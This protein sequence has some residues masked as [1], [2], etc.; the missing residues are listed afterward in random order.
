MEAYLPSLGW[1]GFD[2]TN[3]IMAAERHIRAAVGRDYADGKWDCDDLTTLTRVLNRGLRPVTAVQDRVGQ[4]VG[5]SMVISG[6]IAIVPAW[7]LFVPDASHLGTAQLPARMS[8]SVVPSCRTPSTSSRAH[9]I[10]KSTCVMLLLPP[11]RSNSSSV[12]LSPPST[13][14]R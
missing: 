14:N 12:M 8:G 7:Y 1:V 2:P 9:P 10:M 5:A 13:V 4:A 3:N 6:T 11:A